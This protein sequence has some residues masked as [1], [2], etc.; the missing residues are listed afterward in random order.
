MRSAQ[1]RR[2]VVSLPAP[3]VCDGER[4]RPAGGGRRAE[5]TAESD[6]LFLAR[7]NFSGA[8]GRQPQARARRGS[9]AWRN[10]TDCTWPL[11]D[12]DS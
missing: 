12:L 3:V 7:A 6:A 11:R 2:S 4:A 9:E 8:G 5:P 1:I 10:T